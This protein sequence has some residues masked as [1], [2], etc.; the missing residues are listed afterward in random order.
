MSWTEQSIRSLIV[1][2]AAKL[3]FDEV[4]IARAD[5]LAK[6]AQYMDEWLAKDYH[7]TMSYLERNREKRYDPRQL[8]EGT[9]TVVT[10]LQN[11]FPSEVPTTT[12]N[13]RIAK[14]AFGKDYHRVIRDKLRLMLKAI[15]AETGPLKARA[16]TDSAPVLDRAW[17]EVCGL[18][19]IG[20][21]TCLINPRKGS[22]FFIGHLF[23][24]LEVAEK[25]EK[26]SDYC[27]TC[28]RCIDACPT[29]ALAGP[30]LLDANKCISYLTIEYK[31]NLPVDLR[32][33]FAGYIFG[34]DICQDVCPWNRFAQ[35][36]NEPLF[37][38][39]EE[40]KSMR[41]RD[42]LLLDEQ[43]FAELFSDSAVQR[44]GFSGLK[45]NIEFLASTKDSTL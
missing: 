14:Y 35:P 42:W 18:G 20:K 4:G 12:N 3:G 25:K 2:Q 15:E 1:D 29:E 19:F 36:H 43:R 17:A 44:T 31:G 41:L 10:V 21:N 16:F 27:G 28:R 13:F 7:G 22:Y 32:D 23:L 39:R 9:K 34:C 6:H 24:P 40:L 11:Y 33:K 8:L 26:V 30:H 38:M 45:R 37:A 5:F